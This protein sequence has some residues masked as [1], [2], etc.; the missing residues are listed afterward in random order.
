VARRAAAL[1]THRVRRRDFPT[2]Q[3]EH[4]IDAVGSNRLFVDFPTQQRAIE[5]HAPVWSVVANSAHENVPG[6][7]D[8]NSAMLSLLAV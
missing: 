4:R 8:E 1:R 7:C 3:G 5:L 6:A 2:A